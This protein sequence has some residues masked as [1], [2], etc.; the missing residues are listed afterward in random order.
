MGWTGEQ[1]KRSGGL[2][3]SEVRKGV[4]AGRAW[5]KALKMESVPF[6]KDRRPNEG[7]GDKAKTSHTSH[8]SIG[9]QILQVWLYRKLLW[10]MRYDGFGE[11]ILS[12]QLLNPPTSAQS[13][14]VSA[15]ADQDVGD[16]VSATGCQEVCRASM[17][18]GILTPWGEASSLHG[19][20]GCDFPWDT[21]HTHWNGTHCLTHASSAHWF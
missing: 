1:I 9:L 19:S 14:G 16:P 7:Q 8:M 17:R 10:E 6:L 11:E 20:A 13:T 2:T 21:P 3:I 4:F 12:S 15:A 18:W 5:Q